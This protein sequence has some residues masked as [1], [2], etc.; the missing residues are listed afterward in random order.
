MSQ[1]NILTSTEIMSSMSFRPE[2]Y[3]HLFGTYLDETCWA[4]RVIRVKSSKCWWLKEVEEVFEG[5]AMA[6]LLLLL[7][8]KCQRCTSER[9]RERERVQLPSRRRGSKVQINTADDE[10]GEITEIHLM[11]QIQIQLKSHICEKCMQRFS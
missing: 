9:E 6:R 3:P 8:H 10:M 7:G 2:T 4:F 11:I 1:R 5:A